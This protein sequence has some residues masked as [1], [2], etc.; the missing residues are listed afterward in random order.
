VQV[1]GGKVLQM[2]VRCERE[3]HA[4]VVVLDWPEKR[5]AMNQNDVVELIDALTSVA[6]DT[7]VYGVV[8]TGNG[9]FC[10]GGD[11]KHT[12]A[13]GELP[14]DECRTIVY[15][16]YQNLIRT[17]INLPVLTVA[18]VDG[19]AVGLGSLRNC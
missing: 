3:G 17:L 4:A 11:L 14:E 9:A 16:K 2:G 7:D 6:R 15:S 19:P 1:A 10:A 5:N 13:I 18:A 8:I 12:V